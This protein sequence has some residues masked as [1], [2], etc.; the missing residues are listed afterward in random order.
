MNIGD[1]AKQTDIS[2]KMIRHYESI[3]LLPESMRTDAGYRIYRDKDLYVLRFIKRAR[4]LGFSMEQIKE[5]LSLWQ[6]QGRASAD[7]KVIAERHVA[8]L[9]QRI[10]ELTE[11]RDTLSHLAACCHG[12]ERPDCPILSGLEGVITKGC[13]H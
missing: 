4:N 5:L 9:Q 6:D 11:M 1:A 13:C 3:G 12:D 8:E 10:T 7:V 2:A